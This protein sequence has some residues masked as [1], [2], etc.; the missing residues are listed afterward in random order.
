MI[1]CT[2]THTLECWEPTYGRFITISFQECSHQEYRTEPE[3]V[4]IRLIPNTDKL[5]CVIKR[6]N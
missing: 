5:E 3:L 1:E 6:T 2:V 4:S